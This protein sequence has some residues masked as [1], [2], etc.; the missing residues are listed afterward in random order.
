MA[1]WIFESILVLAGAMVGVL[2]WFVW[3]WRRPVVSEASNATTIGDVPSRGFRGAISDLGLGAILSLI[4]QEKKSGVLTV[5]REDLV[6]HLTCRAGEVLTASMEVRRSAADEEAI[7]VLL[8][9]SDGTFIF[10]PKTVSSTAPA[11]KPVVHLLM[12]SA[13]RADAAKTQNQRSSA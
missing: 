4:S 6:G 13:R 5:W 10:E 11:L 9:L 3:G 8:G 2:P 12:E 1:P 7:Y